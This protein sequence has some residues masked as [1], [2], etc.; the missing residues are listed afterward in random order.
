MVCLKGENMKMMRK[1]KEE[2]FTLVELMI[3]VA[4]IGILSA[5]AIP[6][7]KKYQ[8]K[9]K[10][11]EAKISLSSIYTAETSWFGDNDGFG[12]CLADMGYSVSNAEASQRYFAVGF[13]AAENAANGYAT[14][15]G[16]TC[17]N[18]IFVFAG[19]KSV[20]GAPTGT[21]NVAAEGTAVVPAAANTFVAG[22]VGRISA[23][24]ATPHRT[25]INQNKTIIDTAQGY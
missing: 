4:I 6:N 11:S 12:T 2:G 17:G 19:R 7:F 8:A 18:T 3:V 13:T 22:A 23:D 5:V 24:I 21:A 15:K 20:A 9:A 25:T 14:S 10:V 16:V 1:I